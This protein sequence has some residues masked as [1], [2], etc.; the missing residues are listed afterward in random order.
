MLYVYAQSDGPNSFCL[1]PDDEGGAVLATE[2]L[3]ALGRKRIAHITGPERF[4][5]VRLR[6]NGYRKA[7]KR[8]GL[9]AREDFYLSGTWSEE[10]GRDAVGKLFASPKDVPDAIFCGNDQIARGVADSLRERG[11][12][13]PDAVSIVG[14]D[15][16]EIVAGAT[17][18]PL[19][20]IDMNLK[21]LGHEAGRG[22]IDLI[23][24]KVL[25]GVMAASLQSGRS[26]VLRRS[27]S[28]PPPAAKSEEASGA[29]S[30]AS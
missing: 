17:R 28:P 3:I 1:V 6:R 25:S 13:V 10:W 29:P 8:G 15:N 30:S 24:G 18:P 26:R 7:L 21:E 12:V 5:A 27:R 23:A 14:F 20:S 9:Q 22:L 16:W 4:E 2:H 19:T 11:I